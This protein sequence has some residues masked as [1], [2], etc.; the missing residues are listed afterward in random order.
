MEYLANILINPPGAK[1]A[2]LSITRKAE[3]NVENRLT[4]IYIQ[5]IE[6]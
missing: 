2:A 1:A 3:I 4:G 6:N 5:A